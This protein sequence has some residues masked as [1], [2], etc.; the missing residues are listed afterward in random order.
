MLCQ[1]SS[2]AHNGH[3]A[4]RNRVVLRLSVNVLTQDSVAHVNRN[5]RS[6]GLILY[7]KLLRHG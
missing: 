5:V 7:E 6:A 2:A 3:D 1:S 4:G